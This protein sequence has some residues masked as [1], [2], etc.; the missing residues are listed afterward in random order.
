MEIVV[1]T[2][3]IFTLQFSAFLFY[4]KQHS[5]NLHVLYAEAAE[6]TD[7]IQNIVFHALAN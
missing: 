5:A 7:S 1:A 4:N 3:C 2:F 6:S